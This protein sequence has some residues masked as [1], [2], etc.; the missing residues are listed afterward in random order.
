MKTRFLA[1]TLLLALSACGQSQPDIDELAKEYLFLEL[2]MG[3]HD[4]SHVDAYFGPEE[5]KSA[6]EEKAL[7]LDQILAASTELAVR[8]GGGVTHAA[9]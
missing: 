2:S 6:A 4:K 3:L 5:L 8:L 9:P 7:S 1:F